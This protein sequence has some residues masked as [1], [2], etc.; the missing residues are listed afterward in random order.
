MHF[1]I[2]VPF[3]KGKKYGWRKSP[4]L[5]PD[6]SS[7]TRSKGR[8]PDSISGFG[9]KFSQYFEI[10]SHNNNFGIYIL[11][12]VQ[13][14]MLTHTSLTALIFQICLIVICALVCNILVYS[15]LGIINHYFTKL[16]ICQNSVTPCVCL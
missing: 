15:V 8:S 16:T 12:H 4:L 3:W 2:K 5:S 11:I 1:S 13:I 14:V 10:T 6:S 7:H 9:V